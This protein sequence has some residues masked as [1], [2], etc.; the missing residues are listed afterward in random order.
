MYADDTTLQASDSDIVALQD[1]LNSDLSAI[2][3][4]F[5]E[6]RLV[7]NTDKTVCMLLATHQRKATVPDCKLQLK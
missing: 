6:N 7:L 1:K 2:N 4:W 5:Y 3:Q